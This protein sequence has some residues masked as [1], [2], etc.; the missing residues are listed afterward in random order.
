MPYLSGFSKSRQ[1]ITF[2]LP[3]IAITVVL[4]IVNC[5]SVGVEADTT[6]GNKL[7]YSIV[8]CLLNKCIHEW[9]NKITL[10]TI[11]I[12]RHSI[13]PSII[14]NQFVFINRII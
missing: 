11:V 14:Y 7:Y 12:S 10:N 9:L 3:P 5:Y 13:G 1:N 2:S 6:V 8:R 4:G